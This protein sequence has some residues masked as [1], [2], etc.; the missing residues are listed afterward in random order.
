MKKKSIKLN[1]VMNIILTMSSFIFPLITFPYVS[2]VLLPVGTGKVSMAT[3]VIT[4][5]SMFAQLG[6][7]TYGIRA[8]AKVRDNREKLSKVAQELLIINIIMSMISYKILHVK[9]SDWGQLLIL[10]I[11][12]L[13][14]QFLPRIVAPVLNLNIEILLGRFLVFF[15]GCWCGKKVYQNACINNIDKMGILFG[16]MIMLC[17]F[18]PVTKIVVSKLGFRILMCFWG[19][20]LLYCIAVSMRKMPK[21]IVKILEQFGKMSY[22]LY[23]THVAIRAL[24]NVIGIKTFYFQNYVFGILIS[25][26]L[27]YTIVKLQKKLI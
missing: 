23:L 21:R 7:P 17:G 25:L 18:L 13:V 22:E 15:I 27:T 9:W 2:R 19:I 16:V 1:F 14:I 10:L 12:A 11:I 6:I 4:Y 8:C 26:F 5:F 20:F 3:S 24:M